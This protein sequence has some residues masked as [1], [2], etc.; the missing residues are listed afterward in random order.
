MK[1]IALL[2]GLSLVLASTFLFAF[3]KA[4]KAGQFDDLES[5]G[6]R[7]LD[8]KSSNQVNHQKHAKR[9]V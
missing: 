1:V 3:Y 2:I 7:I 4:M 5:P 6:M 9:N 8:K